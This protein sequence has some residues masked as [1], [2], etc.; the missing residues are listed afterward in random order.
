MTMPQYIETRDEPL[1]PKFTAAERE[2]Y[3]WLWDCGIRP[4]TVD[5]IT[6]YVR[7]PDATYSSLVEYRRAI[8]ERL[9]KR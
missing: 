2:A 5:L 1:P 9:T 8:E 3:R 7:T 6:K 4:W